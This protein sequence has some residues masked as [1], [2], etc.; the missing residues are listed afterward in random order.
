[1]GKDEIWMQYPFGNFKTL[2]PNA[3]LDSYEPEELQARKKRIFS[4]VQTPAFE[5]L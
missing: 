5:K 2:F 4:S 3:Q 1:M